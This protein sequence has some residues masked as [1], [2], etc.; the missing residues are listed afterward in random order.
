LCVAGQTELA[1]DTACDNLGSAAETVKL[2]GSHHFNG[3]YDAVGQAVLTFID[4]TS[5]SK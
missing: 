4:K 2:P 3:N 1:A 5:R